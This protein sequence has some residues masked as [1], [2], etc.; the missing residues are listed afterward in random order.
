[1]TRWPVTRQTRR[2]APILLALAL[3]AGSVDAITY[4]RIGVFP[5]NMTGNTVLLA[6]A[7]AR[8]NG[9]QAAHSATALGGFALGV[10]LGVALMPRRGRAWPHTAVRTLVVELA[11]LVALTA[12]SIFHGIPGARYELILLASAAMGAQS[13]AVRASDVTGVTTTYMTGTYMNAVARAVNRLR[14]AS[15]SQVRPPSL[16]GAAWITYAVGALAGAGAEKAWHADSL[17]IPLTIVALVGAAS[18]RSPREE[19]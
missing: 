2:E 14:G 3:A 7:V 4:L 18:S 15:P 8:R 19:D 13:A 5:A 1:M 11:A 17:F 6:V 10:A 12:Y 16:P 9:A